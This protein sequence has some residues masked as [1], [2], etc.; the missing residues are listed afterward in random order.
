[1]TATTAASV[2]VNQPSVMPPI[3]IT[4]AINAITAE[5]LKR[6]SSASNATNAMPVATLGDTP[7]SVINQMDKGKDSTISSAIENSSVAAKD[8][9]V[10]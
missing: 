8:C 4:G 1:M 5:K 2:G 7:A 6:Q 3:R 10:K 9:E